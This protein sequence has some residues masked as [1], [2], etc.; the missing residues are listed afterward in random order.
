MFSQLGYNPT[1]H[2]FTLADSRRI[3]DEQIPHLDFIIIRPF[4]SPLLHVPIVAFGGEYTFYISRFVVWLQ[5]AIISVLLNRF[6]IKSV[7]KSITFSTEFFFTIITFVM[8]VHTFPIMAW[9]TIDGLM[10]SVIGLN[11]F[12]K[13]SKTKI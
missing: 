5:F 12:I 1:D 11:L 6:I 3:L 9:H 7:F 4:L 10:F 13:Y 8:A 2:G